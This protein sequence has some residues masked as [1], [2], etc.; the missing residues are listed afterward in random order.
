MTG[1]GKDR[2]MLTFL[3]SATTDTGLRSNNEDAYLV[4]PERGLAAVSDGMGGAAAG[5]VASGIFVQTVGELF[6]GFTPVQAGDASTMVREAFRLSNERIIE[7]VARNYG[8]RGMGCTAE[9]LVFTGD[10]YVLGHVGDSR[11]YLL[12]G[13]ELRQLTRD[14]SLVQ[15]EVDLGRISAQQAKTHPLRNIVLRALGSGIALSPDLIQGR[16]LPGDLFLLCSDGLTEKL[17]DREIAGM[18]AY[19]GPL[20]EKAGLLVR[21]A[22]SAG[23]SDNVTVVLSQASSDPSSHPRNSS[24]P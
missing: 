22:K 18:L 10:R 23:G 4:L 16:V 8:H 14:H 12:R 20:D 15:Q 6:A 17:D 9:L 1:A 24:P 11:G 19:R 2:T 3:F 13:G 5:E 7:H 21:R